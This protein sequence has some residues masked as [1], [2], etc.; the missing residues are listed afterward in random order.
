MSPRRRCAC[1]RWWGAGVQKRSGTAAGD[2]AGAEALAGPAGGGRWRS[3]SR[4]GWPILFAAA[5]RCSRARPP[6]AAQCALSSLYQNQSNLRHLADLNDRGGDKAIDP[7]GEMDRLIVAAIHTVTPR[8]IVANSTSCA[9]PCRHA[10]PIPRWRL[11]S[12]M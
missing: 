11:S 6:S 8:S 12:L 2:A 4:R 10:A 7:A 1:R 3:R 5:T 9:A